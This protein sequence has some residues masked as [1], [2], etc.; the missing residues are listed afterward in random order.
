MKNI[1]YYSFCYTEALTVTENMCNLPSLS[2][3]RLKILVMV[4]LLMRKFVAAFTFCVLL[5]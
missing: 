3:C 1:S 5:L 4:K 2:M